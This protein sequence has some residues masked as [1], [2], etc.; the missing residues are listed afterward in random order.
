MHTQVRKGTTLESINIIIIYFMCFNKKNI[1]GLVEVR[2]YL[3][4]IPPS[5]RRQT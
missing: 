1:P 4:G 2:E 3:V 5:I